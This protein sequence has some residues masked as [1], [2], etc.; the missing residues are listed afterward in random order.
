MK[1]EKAEAQDVSEGL[2]EE[3]SQLKAKLSIQKQNADREIIQLKAELEKEIASRE[4]EERKIAERDGRIRKLTGEVAQH[5]ASIKRGEDEV[6][7]LMDEVKSRD[8]MDR[9]RKDNGGRFRVEVDT[10][11]AEL[12]K[13]EKTTSGGPRRD[14]P[15]Q[16]DK[17]N[18]ED[19]VTFLR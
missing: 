2:K 19:K 12:R 18:L 9:D 11:S 1:L 15:S 8:Q 3:I 7:R 6:T 16:K 10:M 13:T 14:P 5:L 4:L 17:K